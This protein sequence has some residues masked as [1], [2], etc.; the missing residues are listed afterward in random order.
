MGRLF[1]QIKQ[2]K[3]FRQFLLRGLN[4]VRGEWAI[5]RTIHNLLKLHR[6]IV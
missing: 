2:P 6:A 4:N 1:G 5:I 3:G